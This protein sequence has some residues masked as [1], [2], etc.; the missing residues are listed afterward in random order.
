MKKWTALLLTLVL[1][2]SLSVPA[3]A[4]DKAVLSNQSLSVDGKLIDC[5]LYKFDVGYDTEKRL[6]SI[7][8]NHAY[9][10]PQPSDLVPGEDQSATTVSSSQSIMI[11]G[12]LRDD[13]TAY[14]IGGYNFF[15]LRELG[16][17]LGF[18]VDYDIPTR[19]MLVTSR[20]TSEKTTEQIYAS[21]MPAVFYIEV[22]SEDG[23]AIASGS[24]FFIDANGTAVTNHHV[25]YG[26]SSAKVTLSDSRGSSSGGPLRR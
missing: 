14:N 25:I 9:T 22:Y 7:T 8:T 6:I 23:Y 1:L 12:A 3:L 18:Y 4:F 20:D 21:C 5:E 16:A 19:T 26:A 11:N 24:G 13:L 15:Q 17:A 2:F 10:D